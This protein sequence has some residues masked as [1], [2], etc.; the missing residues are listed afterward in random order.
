MRV[1]SPRTFFFGVKRL[2]Q[3]CRTSGALRLAFVL[4]LFG[5]FTVHA[6]GRQSH[7]R[8]DRLSLEQGLSQSIVNVI[9]K[10][11][12][13]FM[14]FGTESGLNRYDG[15][16]FKIYMHD[17]FDA[18][19]LSE[20]HI[21][22]IAE[23]KSGELWIGTNN[24][25]LNRYSWATGS[26]TR[27]T[28]V[29][30]DSGTIGNNA[31]VFVYIDRSDNVWVF[32]RAGGVDR[33]DKRRDSFLRIR[34]DP[35]DSMSLSHDRITSLFE[36]SEGRLWFGTAHGLN[37]LVERV[38][39][40][41]EEKRYAFEHSFMGGDTPG[42]PVDASI[43]SLQEIPSE[44]GVLWIGA[45][46][47]EPPYEGVGLVRLDTRTGE[48]QWFRHKERD[49]RT[50][51]SDAG[52]AVRE[53]QDGEI[54]VA[55]ARG[56]D[57]FDPETRTFEHF[58][59]EP[60]DPDPAANM[61]RMGTQDINGDLWITTI[62]NRGIYQFTPSSGTFLRHSNIPS[63][64]HSLSNNTVT[65]LYADS[66]GV[67]WIGTNT[68][69]LN[70]LDLYGRKFETYGWNPTDPNSLS[71]PIARAF[72][73]GRDGSLYVGV[74]GGGL[75][76]Y[77]RKRSI[78]RHYRSDSQNPRA[79]NDDDVWALLTDPDGS[80]WVGTLGGG[81]NHFDPTTETFTRYVRRQGDSTSLSDDNVR[82]LLQDASGTLWVGT[83][84]GGLNRFDKAKGTFTHYVNDP[85]DS[86]SLSS[87]IVR[88]LAFDPDGDLWVGTFLGGLCKFDAKT[89]TFRRYRHDPADPASLSSD[90]I[91]SLEIASDGSLWIGTFGGGLCRMDRNTE[92]FRSYT[93]QNSELPNNTV[94]AVLEDTHRNIWVSS[95]MGLTRFD[96]ERE[97]F[98]TYDTDDGLQSREFNGQ[99]CF[100]SSTGEMF[101][102]GIEGFNAF[103]PDRIVDNPFEPQMAITGFLL[104]NQPV[105][106]GGDSPLQKHISETYEITLRYW[107]NYITFEFVALQYNRP[108]RNQYRYML[109]NYDPTWQVVR[110]RRSATYTNLE[111]G[112]YYFR[113][114]G[115]N[116][117][118]LWNEAGASIRIVITPPWWR[119]IQAY[120]SYAV[121]LVLVVGL[122][123][124]IERKRLLR[125][126]REQAA[127]R[128]AELRA[129]T[130]EAQARAIEAENL[131]KTQ[132]L[133]QA[134]QL[135]LSM[136]PRQLPVVP[137]LEI[138]VYMQPA[139]EVGGDY[140]D[141]AVDETG[142]LTIVV[143][144]ATGHGL[145]A[146][147]MVSVVKSLFIAEP[148]QR[149]F[150]GFFERCTRTIRR[151]H[152]GNLYMGLS[153]VRIERDELHLSAAGMPP[154]YVYRA[155]T[156]DIEE[157]VVKGMPL[158]AVD[159]FAYE[160]RSVRL[161]EGDSILLL[162]DGLPELFNDAREPF[163]YAR[164]RAALRSS[165]GGPAESIV[166][167]L[168]QEGEGWR[169]GRTPNDDMT[170]V[171]I[172]I[173]DGHQG[174]THG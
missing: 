139:T 68:G 41:P 33:Y 170:F 10:D 90:M 19:S 81:L 153:L 158:G 8:F 93:Q 62:A 107:Q 152:L 113:V 53:D 30:N 63:D 124:Q 96:P 133:E 29:P 168:V 89:G 84:Q 7:L 172:K 102:G 35:A 76:R 97:V 83:D 115:S 101:F 66:M 125:R 144:D 104:Y 156:G 17:P 136:L 120:V 73:E 154:A 118:G 58:I 13:G 21:L 71:A 127:I 119:T 47:A 6:V 138:A 32:T 28:S 95:N 18:S 142:A 99:A 86:T 135:Q 146:G 87:N 140:Y 65:S 151:L 57:R 123:Y 117:D 171:V 103:Y 105:P 159:H 80:L 165:G 137:N 56:L 61:I 147:T 109:V 161:H 60:N 122:F 26:F 42:T 110:D 106:I 85:S 5:A 49:R 45:G 79:L 166:E 141:F 16:Q 3:A 149:D 59:P 82:V 23:D 54:W 148:P 50:I 145:S 78:V 11:Q 15:Y 31:V 38:G 20:N 46:R 9:H 163:D 108:E 157:L 143:G 36:D 1:P 77:N 121:G 75:N 164:V 27:Y 70:K 167:H 160:E 55:T 51:S 174:S 91:Q 169:K 130:A 48:R 129:Q 92:T 100:K 67:L 126:E 155:K 12:K 43:L 134:R 14:W 72:A 112:E 52:V 150:Q 74:A 4:L 162:S 173:K 98:Q 114:R 44:P 132:E 2:P 34:H 40:Y 39:D 24:G 88:A 25:G 69:G 22:T 128:E 64:P 111:P 94:Y 131:R 116:S 37:R